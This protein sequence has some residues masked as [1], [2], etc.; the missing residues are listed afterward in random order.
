MSDTTNTARF[1]TLPQSNGSSLVAASL[2]DLP[3]QS[4]GHGAEGNQR[5][6]FPSFSSAPPRD[7]HPPAMR[8]HPILRLL[9]L[10][11]ASCTLFAQCRTGKS[12][13]QLQN[14]RRAAQ[15]RAHIDALLAEVH[16]IMLQS[17]N[18]PNL[19]RNHLFPHQAHAISV[20]TGY[21]A[22]GHGSGGH[23]RYGHSGNGHSGYGHSGYGHH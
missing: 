19:A 10:C 14:E 16:Q 11:L 8:R 13:W 23:S 5:E 18:S 21:C 1:R 9:L 22:P 4:R 17:G 15:H 7:P 3:A 12:A 2:T 20:T 6:S